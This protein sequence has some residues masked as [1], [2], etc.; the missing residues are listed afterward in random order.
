MKKVQLFSD[1][2][3]SLG[4]IHRLESAGMTTKQVELVND[5]NFD[6][7][8]VFNFAVDRLPSGALDQQVIGLVLEP[9]EILDVMYMG[10]DGFDT[11]PYAGY[12]AFANDL[13]PGYSPAPGVGFPQVDELYAELIAP[14]WDQ[15][16]HACM[17]VSSKTYTAYQR[18]RREVFQALLAT[19]LDID[20]YGRGMD[21]D[22]DPRLKGEIPQGEKERVLTQ[23]KYVIDFENCPTALTDKFFDPVL[24]GATPVTNSRIGLPGHGW[25]WVD[26]ERS[27]DEIIRMIKAILS[28]DRTPPDKLLHT[29]VTEGYLSLTAWID[30]KATELI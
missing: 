24:C 27:I 4:L 22:G 20:F 23:Y 17:I 15:R 8:V 28:E 14:S 10:W 1:W 16:K 26:F 6:V 12:Y 11:S 21:T 30:R 5:Y 25:E 2:D 3:D 18:R 7:A 19:D 13:G 29:E 9:K